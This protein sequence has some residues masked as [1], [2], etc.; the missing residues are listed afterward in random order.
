MA[1]RVS[2]DVFYEYQ[3]GHHTP[4]RYSDPV[5]YSAAASLNAKELRGPARSDALVCSNT[6]PVSFLVCKWYRLTR[7]PCLCF[8]ED[9]ILGI[10]RG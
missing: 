2:L 10:D 7:F 5:H 3:H 1:V 4:R 8:K 6:S 9:S